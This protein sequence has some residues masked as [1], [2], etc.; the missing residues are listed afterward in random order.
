MLNMKVLLVDDHILFREGLSSLLTRLPNIHIIGTAESVAETVEKT[1]KL[2]PDLIL[3]N[4][5]LSD[6]TGLEATQAI[7]AERPATNIV[8]L[9][10]CDKDE[11][12]FEALRFGA[13]GYLNKSISLSKFLKYI[14]S[15]EVDDQA[16]TEP[17]MIN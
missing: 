13:M 3:M 10:T 17:I 2:E 15:L 11:R 8:F 6:G 14:R 12:L 7:L 1:R 5:D 4:F 9:I 16:T